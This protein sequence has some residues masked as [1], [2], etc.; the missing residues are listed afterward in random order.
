MNKSMEDAL[1]IGQKRG[2]ELIHKLMK[3]E[4]DNRIDRASDRIKWILEKVPNKVEAGYLI[5]QDGSA[6]RF[7]EIADV[8]Q[9]HT[10]VDLSSIMLKL[11]AG[12]T[13][14]LKTPDMDE[15]IRSSMQCPHC[16]HRIEVCPKCGR[17]LWD[18]SEII[19]PS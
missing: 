17:S 6:S 15:L 10:G 12:E 2:R 7:A 3:W 1:G 5:W 18:D 8:F 14:G 9:R 19:K 13:V 4:R 11:Q 16:H